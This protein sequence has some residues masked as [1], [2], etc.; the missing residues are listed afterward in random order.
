MYIVSSYTLAV[1]L[2]VV[3]M[4]CWGS[5]ANTQ[6]LAQKSWRFELFYWDYVLGIV[7]M[8][9]LFA[10]T[11]G[12]NGAVGR[13]FTEDLSQ[14][15][16]GNMGNAFLGGIIFNA[17]NILVSAAI[18]IAGM[19]VAFPVGI[20][21]ALV[22]GV[23]INYLAAPQGNAT[24]LFIGVSLVAFAIV[25]D[26]IAYRKKTDAG[27]TSLSKGLLFA[28]IGGVLMALF[29]RF[30][31]S[32]MATDFVNP[33][34]GLLTP[35]TAVFIFSLGIFASNFVFNTI[36]MRNPV[37]GGA[38]SYQQYFG[39]A[40]KEHLT[41]IFG[42][43]IWCVG[44]MLSIIASGEAGFAISYGLGQGATMV[45]AIWGVFIWKEFKGVQGVNGLL[46]AMFICFII[47]LGM[48]VYA[49]M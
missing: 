14:A 37:E 36:F 8:S 26:A 13:S 24:F 39:G 34:A 2:C 16:L 40:L 42:G 21:I 17:A 49:G 3:T 4:L 7:I 33:Q 11:L 41:G 30:V 15:D 28:I 43:F 47:G 44:M 38:V 1:I 5:W 32:S 31:A 48:I 25:I 29:Y 12:S 20:G 23:V 27:N 18:A 19:S 35:Y 6:K 9:L 22:L 46:A 10:F 45:A